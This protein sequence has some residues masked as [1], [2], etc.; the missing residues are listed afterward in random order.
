MEEACGHGGCA[1]VA[2]P[3]RQ[4]LVRWPGQEGPP[5]S[6]GLSLGDSCIWNRWQGKCHLPEDRKVPQ[7]GSV[8]GG[9]NRDGAGGSPAQES[10]RGS[11]RLQSWTS[12]ALMALM[13]QE[14]RRGRERTGA[15][16][17]AAVSVCLLGQ[18][19]GI[20]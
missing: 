11:G 12:E 1:T 17:G 10:W 13:G 16:M 18:T 4:S 5:I 15:D 6:D 19:C 2:W 3:P 20:L 7:A 8:A 14:G 9:R